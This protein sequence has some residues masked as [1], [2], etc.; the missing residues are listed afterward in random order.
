M[1]QPTFPPKSWWALKTDT[2]TRGTVIR[3]SPRLKCGVLLAMGGQQ[4]QARAFAPD[5]LQAVPG[6]LYGLPGA[7]MT[8]GKP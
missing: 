8:G 1:S 5:E 7:L 4:D 3:Y 6:P 2:K